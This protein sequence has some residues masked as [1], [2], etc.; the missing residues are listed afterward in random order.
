MESRP[1]AASPFAPPQAPIES[2]TTPPAGSFVFRPLAGLAR[3]WTVVMAVTVLIE[4]VIV[5]SAGMKLS[6][7]ERM[8]VDSEGGASLSELAAMDESSLWIDVTY[9][10]VAVASVVIFCMIMVRSNRNASSFNTK[11]MH[12]TPGWAAGYFFVPVLALWKPYQAMREIWQASSPIRYDLDFPGLI[13]L[14]WA[15]FLA[16]SFA[17][18]LLGRLT[19]RA[20]G[21]EGLHT[22]TW[23]EIISSVA[24]I[25]AAVL[26]TLLVRA[27][28]V[29][30][31]Q[32]PADAQSMTTTG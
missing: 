12:F 16:H 3:A 28:A 14:W 11:V 21:L 27:L 19:L 2:P 29:R 4:L 25:I 26:S 30:Q 31:D 32:R 15:A 1:P 18:Q 10:L 23:V 8:K 20:K 7:L 22:T 9:A 17:G 6:L 13:P 24:T 5:A